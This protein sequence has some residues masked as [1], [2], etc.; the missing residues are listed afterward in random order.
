MI[1]TYDG[2]MP[3]GSG[4]RTTSPRCLALLVVAA[5]FGFGVGTAQAGAP[6]FTIATVRLGMTLGEVHGALGKPLA[7]TRYHGSSIWHYSDTLSVYLSRR[8]NAR[9]PWVVGISTRSPQDRIPSLGDLHVGSSMQAVERISGPTRAC[10]QGRV[11]DPL[12]RQV[13]GQF[14]QWP[15]YETA[16]HARLTNLSDLPVLIF[17]MRS[18]HITQITAQVGL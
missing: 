8:T 6:Q 13:G 1:R 18:N 10:F 3:R 14:C 15:V 11:R 9:M 4:I 7:T 16:A 5:G 12:F 17:R 2:R